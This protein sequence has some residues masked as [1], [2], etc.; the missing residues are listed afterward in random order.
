MPR[1]EE[2][3]QELERRVEEEINEGIL[4]A[5]SAYYMNEVFAWLFSSQKLTPSLLKLNEPSSS[6]SFYGL[7]LNG[8]RQRSLQ[9]NLLRG[10][11]SERCK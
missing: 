11:S 9:F 6:S 3:R 1:S 8:R 2:R 5:T 10:G 7:A 4:P